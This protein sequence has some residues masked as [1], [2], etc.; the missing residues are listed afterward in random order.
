MTEAQTRWR[1]VNLFPTN[2]NRQTSRIWLIF[3]KI[4]QNWAWQFCMRN[5]LMGRWV[6]QRV[7][8]FRDKSTVL[9]RRGDTNSIIYWF[10]CVLGF[11][12]TLFSSWEFTVSIVKTSFL[13]FSFQS[14]FLYDSCNLNT[15]IE[16]K[17]NCGQNIAQVVW[18][19]M[20]G[21]YLR[22]TFTSF[23]VHR[24]FYQTN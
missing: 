2:S 24:S 7:R 9:R 21:H 1:K 5:K 14:V 17:F 12:S 19:Q 16:R 22:S 23:C 10:P 4:W 13:G 6:L 15:F 3:K 18:E 11:R 8:M 20:L